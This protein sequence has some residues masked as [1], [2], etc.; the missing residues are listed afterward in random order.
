MHRQPASALD[1]FTDSTRM[2]GDSTIVSVMEFDR[3][4]DQGRLQEAAGRCFGAYPIL[5]ARLVRGDGPAHWDLQPLTSAMT[6]VPVIDVGSDDYRRYVT[7]GVDPYAAPQAVFR[8]LRSSEKDVLVINMAHAAADGRGMKELAWTLMRAYLDP[9]SVLSNG[10]E[11]PT[12]DTLWTEGLLDGQNVTGAG[13]VPLINPMWPNPFPPSKAP[14][15]YHRTIICPEGMATLKGVAKDHGGTINDLFMAAYFLAMSDLT[16]HDGPQGLFFPV[17]LRRYLTDG[18]RIMSN[19]SANVSIV[20]VREPGDD[21]GKILD[22]VVRETA[23]LKRHKIGIWEQVAFDRGSDP[24]GR[25]VHSMV[26]E[27]VRLQDEEG[28]ADVFIT[29]P[30][31]MNLPDVPGLADAYICYPGTY[32]PAACFVI[33]TFR[34]A[35]SVT[36][37]YQD[38][39]GSM[40]TTM[41][42]MRGFIGHLPLEE[43][44]VLILGDGPERTI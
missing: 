39:E 1:L 32:M 10:E 4:L 16:G 44:Q 20:M 28:M 12:R 22:K 18:S 15:T 37:G 43:R 21:I 33:S 14:S 27:M 5:R 35:A 30:G 13:K 29:N 6:D 24:E 2:M 31:P 9:C 38:E 19:Q 36:M 40:K 25:A 26:R 34:D 41:R 11:L 8:I 17:D 3:H 42:A 23:M 7:N